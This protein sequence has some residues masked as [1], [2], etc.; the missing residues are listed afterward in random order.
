VPGIPSDFGVQSYCFRTIETNADVATAVKDIGLDRI[1]VCRKHC[2]FDEPEQHEPCIETYKQAGVT[3]QSLGVE[4]MTSDDAK[5]RNKFEFAKQAGCKHISVNFNLDG[6]DEALAS[7][8][9]LA[10]EY[11]V[12][13]GIHNHGGRHALGSRAVLNYVFG[14]AGDRVGLCL[15]TAWALDSG[16]DPVEM[17]KQYG[18]RLF[19]IHMKDFTFDKARKHTDVVVG[20]GALDLEGLIAAAKEVGFAGESILEYEGDPDNPVPTLKSCVEAIRKSLG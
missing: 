20:A 7:T 6:L 9:K 5:N 2:N 3:I 11:D 15:D 10:E 14:R 4:M 12:R 19:A 18:D 16:E 13:C 17:V 8:Q 1:E